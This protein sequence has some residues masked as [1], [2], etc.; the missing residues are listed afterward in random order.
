LSP[1]SIAIKISEKSLDA[2]PPSTM[3]GM[4]HLSASTVGSSQCDERQRLQGVQF[5]APADDVAFL[6]LRP[7]FSFS[8]QQP[9]TPKHSDSIPSKEPSSTETYE[10]N[11]SNMWV[12]RCKFFDFLRQPR[13][14]HVYPVVG[15]SQG[16]DAA[17]NNDDAGR[18]A[19]GTN[20]C[21]QTFQAFRISPQTG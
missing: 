1:R 21:G 12:G 5:I 3:R 6:S 4:T 13:P 11:L 15:K 10:R 19:L 18:G 17:D 16:I 7:F 9:L 14:A 20:H 2:I 8:Q